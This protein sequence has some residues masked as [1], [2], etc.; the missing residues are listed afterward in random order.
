M[1][2]R[3]FFFACLLFVFSSCST[4]KKTWA[5]RQYHNTTAKYNGY[6]NGNESLKRGVKK[7]Q[8][9]HKDDYTIVLPIY[10][11]GDL[12]SAK[13]T[14]S[15][16]D[17]AI[18]KASIVIQRHSIKIRG[19]E[20][21]K[22]IDDNYLLIG[23]AYF[24][25]GE[26]E[27]AI[28]TFNYIKNEYN[29]NEIRFDAAVWLIKSYSQ[30]KDFVAAEVELEKLKNERKLPKKIEKEL[31]IVSADY[32]L[33]QKNFALALDEL[34]KLT[35]RIK[36]K[37]KKARYN[38]ILA[39]IYQANNNYS[40]AKIKY[41]EVVRA[42]SEYDMVFNA[43]MNLALSS[44]TGTKDGDKMRREL[45]KMTKDDKNKE[46]LDQIF[47]TIGELDINNQDTTSAIE[48][49]LLSTENSLTN[50]G[51]KALS[52]LSLAEIEYTR[53][54][55]EASKTY[56]DSTVYYMHDNF[57]DQEEIKTKHNTLVS[58]M[59]HLEVINLEDSLQGLA[60]LPQQE[61]MEKINQAIQEEIKKEREELQEQQSRQRAMYNSNRNGG[62]GE[63]FGGNTSGGKWYF[64]NP[65]TLSFGMSEFRKKW[66]KRKLEDDWRRKD[67]KTANNFE[68]DTTSTD[69]SRVSSSNK[70][71]P[72]Y[73]LEKIPKT[74]KDFEISDSKIK[75]SIYQAAIIYRD[76]L[77]EIKKSTT[78]FLQIPSKYPEDDQYSP[79]SYYNVYLNYIKQKK[80]EKAKK[81]KVALLKEYPESICAKM[82]L[83]PNAEY[84]VFEKLNKTEKKYQDT[85]DDF[86][87]KKY[88]KVILN[89]S[90]IIDDQYKVK[91]TLLRSLSYAALNNIEGV[92]GELKKIKEFAPESQTLSYV[93]ELLQTMKDPSKMIKANKRA[94]SN[95]LY[96]FKENTPHISVVILP[97]KGID[98][99]FFKTKM[100]DY[101]LEDFEN[102]VFE[103][104]TMLMGIE[105]H[106]LIVKS[107]R[108]ASEAMSYNELLVSS[109]LLKTSLN[110]VNYKLF[111]MSLE[112]F[113]E[114]Y[115][116][117]DIKG[118]AK[119]FKNNY[120]NIK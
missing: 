42:A 114:F 38:Y 44:G 88:Q 79:L 74:E 54:N 26:Y 93:N 49:Y 86:L 14:H 53:T 84:S 51:Q 78:M 46:Y 116:N 39:Q 100:S 75:E 48:H 6:F 118:Y 90:E 66:G 64:Y 31:T 34:K 35:S 106:V 28:K 70:K 60:R 41:K 24:Y 21:C 36:S 55:Y 61:L 17:K 98:I 7:I 73:Y 32:Y 115:K 50:D 18:R 56:Y 85:Y 81:T 12:K 82:L 10:K 120:T 111:A 15:Y 77:S 110:N 57:R 62:R 119:F 63:Q 59:S 96:F 109:E 22:W 25:K 1:Y 3:L 33:K 92:E 83:D 101:H 76:E 80:T 65:A 104:N 47:Y 52:F 20:Y 112:N 19:K 89:T 37:R 97:K 72:K 11:W 27:E 117:K 103:I 113:K 30:N 16:M 71:D 23:K 40:S 29:K 8:E 94:E 4:K 91:Y 5:H 9:N 69:S 43:K 102:E 2:I 105:K 45:L 58:L 87:S 108:S 13:S 99:N 68:G 107:F 67:K 95:S